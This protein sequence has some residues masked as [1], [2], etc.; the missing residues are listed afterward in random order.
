M[1][2]MTM[3]VLLKIPAGKQKV[4]QGKQYMSCPPA[5][6]ARMAV[7]STSSSRNRKGRV[8]RVIWKVGCGDT[9]TIEAIIHAAMEFT[10]G[11]GGAL[12]QQQHR[13]QSKPSCQ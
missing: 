6:W 8:V 5:P 13:G 7:S 11:C 2:S 10:D 1:V 3:T 12:D 9:A 4:V